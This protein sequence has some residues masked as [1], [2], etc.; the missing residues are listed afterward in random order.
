MQWGRNE[1]SNS[2]APKLCFEGP[3]HRRLGLAQQCLV[4]LAILPLLTLDNVSSLPMWTLPC[5]HRRGWIEALM[6]DSKAQWKIMSNSSIKWKKCH[7]N[8]A[9]RCLPNILQKELREGEEEEEELG[10]ASQQ[11][12]P[13]HRSQS[14]KWKY[15]NH[16]KLPLFHST[17]STPYKLPGVSWCLVRPCLCQTQLIVCKMRLHP[18][19]FQR[20]NGILPIS[21]IPRNSP[22]SAAFVQIS[23]FWG[24]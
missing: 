24:F 15:L 12:A 13:V 4:H 18:V 2:L 17:P 6:K 5:R 9:Q 20:K 10:K 23:L 19:A 16:R 1:P 7:P 8:N 3:E 21:L 22:S 14:K 11:Q